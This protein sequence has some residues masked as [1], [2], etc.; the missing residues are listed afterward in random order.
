MTT[1]IPDQLSTYRFCSV[2][3][4]SDGIEFFTD[5]VP[6]V[7]RELPDTIL[8]QAHE[9]DDYESIAARYYSG[10]PNK[11]QLWRII[12]E[13]QPMIP[14]DASVGPTPGSV[15]Y[16]PSRRTLFEDVFS[17]RRREDYEE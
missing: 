4:D 13:F 14:L 6:F 7:Y 2:V 8:H 10:V 15:V 11:A 12:A 17:E 5:P 9:G 1:G 3:T 16:V